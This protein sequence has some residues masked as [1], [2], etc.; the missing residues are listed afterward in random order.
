MQLTVPAVAMKT[1]S[2]GTA[3]YCTICSNDKGVIP[4]ELQPTVPYVAM[5]RE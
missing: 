5:I 2:L 1:K 3:A 4:L